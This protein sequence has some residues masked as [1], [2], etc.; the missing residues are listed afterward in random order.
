MK[1]KHCCVD[2]EDSTN[3]VIITS[4]IHELFINCTSESWTHLTLFF[5]FYLVCIVSNNDT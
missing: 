5:K 2:S 4:V 1:S 3:S